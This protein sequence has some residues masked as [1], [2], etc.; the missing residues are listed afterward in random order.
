M[1]TQV[2]DALIIIVIYF[3]FLYI[4]PVPFGLPYQEMRFYEFFGHP[5]GCIGVRIDFAYQ[6]CFGGFIKIDRTA[7]I[8]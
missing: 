8:P 4:S 6:K 3:M 2:W 1:D 5:E 7:L